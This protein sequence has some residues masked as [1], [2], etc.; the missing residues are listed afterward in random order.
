MAIMVSSYIFIFFNLWL[1]IR[2][3]YLIKTTVIYSRLGR[4]GGCEAPD[5]SP[6]QLSPPIIS[7]E[8]RNKMFS[9]LKSAE[10]VVLHH[11]VKY[12]LALPQ[13]T[14]LSNYYTKTSYYVHHFF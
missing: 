2:R 4:E 5:L 7:A 14:S 12:F 11:P 8:L 9:N 10:L 6:L 13:L 3:Q 1:L